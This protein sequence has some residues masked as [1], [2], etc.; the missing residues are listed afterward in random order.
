M[1]GFARNLKAV[2]ADHYETGHRVV[3]LMK[4]GAKLLWLTRSALGGLAPI[5]GCNSVR[6]RHFALGMINALLMKTMIKSSS[7]TD[8]WI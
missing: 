8:L 7:K 6:D 2:N 5:Y 1:P 3:D 4:K